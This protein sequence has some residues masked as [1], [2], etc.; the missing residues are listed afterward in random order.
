MPLLKQTV[1]KTKAKQIDSKK[2]LGCLL[3]VEG[4]GISAQA[5]DG[6][7][8][9]ITVTRALS[10]DGKSIIFLIPGW[11]VMTIVLSDVSSLP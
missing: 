5:T 3:N 6:A 1:S 2:M 10:F 7:L 8:Q 9:D 4:L 11:F